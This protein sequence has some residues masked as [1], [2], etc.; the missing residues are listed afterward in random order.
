MMILK[1]FVEE[2]LS[3]LQSFIIYV[4]KQLDEK[5]VSRSTRS[6]SND[7]QTPQGTCLIHIVTFYLIIK[8]NPVSS[9]E[10]Q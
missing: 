7:W 3:A 9:N 1:Y 4:N 6:H 2:H 5:L 10:K 8:F